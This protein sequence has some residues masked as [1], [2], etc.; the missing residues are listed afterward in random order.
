[1]ISPLDV[2]ILLNHQIIFRSNNGPQVYLGTL[3][4]YENQM[5]HEQQRTFSSF[6]RNHKKYFAQIYCFLKNKILLT[7]FQSQV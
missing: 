1:M 5:I 6:C 2:A 4:V 3:V 7:K